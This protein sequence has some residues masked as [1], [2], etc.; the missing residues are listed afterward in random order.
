MRNN[1]DQDV[2]QYKRSKKKTQ[3]FFVSK[4]VNK[5]KMTLTKVVQLN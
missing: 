3:F 4:L 5:S 1:R 2:W